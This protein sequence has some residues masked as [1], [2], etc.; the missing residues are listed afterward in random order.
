LN[1]EPA[2]DERGFIVVATQGRGDRGALRAALLS[3]AP[4]VA[5]AGSRR[6]VAGLTAE[7]ARDGISPE[8]L[9]ELRAPAGLRI[10]AIA[11]KEIALSILAEI[12]Q[13]RRR[14]IRAGIVP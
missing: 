4:Y 6:K 1:A 5:F 9:A 12:V 10:G 14:P 3:P 11:P 13:F 8:R 7:L 2:A